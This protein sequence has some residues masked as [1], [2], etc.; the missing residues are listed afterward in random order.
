L[1]LAVSKSSETVPSAVWQDER[2]GRLAALK[3]GLERPD[4]PREDL[5]QAA[6]RG[7]E[8]KE[9]VAFLRAVERCPSARDRALAHLLFYTGLRVGECATL[10]CDDI[11]CG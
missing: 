6:P 10:N 7:L 1:A 2:S 11:A 5:P 9:Q 4:V 3:P 8:E